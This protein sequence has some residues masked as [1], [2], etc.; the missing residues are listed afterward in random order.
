MFKTPK[1]STLQ[2]IALIVFLGLLLFST[3]GT[4]LK[5]QAS[6]LLSFSPK[7]IEVSEQKKLSTY[8]WQ[9]LDAKARTVSLEEFKGKIIFVNFWATWLSTLHCRNAKYG[10]TICGLSGQSSIFICDH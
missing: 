7:T 8:R 4:F 9:L 2:N 5:V 3:V 1:R 6:R 10:Q